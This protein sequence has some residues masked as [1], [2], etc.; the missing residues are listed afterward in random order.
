MQHDGGD[1]CCLVACGRAGDAGGPFF[2]RACPWRIQGRL[3]PR[4]RA[5]ARQGRIDLI[6]RRKERAGGLE[7]FHYRITCQDQAVNDDDFNNQYS[8]VIY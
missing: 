1:R 4:P 8:Q 2:Q 5:A 6:S 7:P 3:R